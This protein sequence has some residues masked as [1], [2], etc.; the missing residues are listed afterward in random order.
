MNDPRKD[1]G[2]DIQVR[3]QVWNLRH[4]FHQHDRLGPQEDH[5]Q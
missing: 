5:N 2:K 3:I 1:D 4:K